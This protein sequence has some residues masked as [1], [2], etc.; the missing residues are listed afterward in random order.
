MILLEAT[1]KLTF[2]SL[3]WGVELLFHGNG[4]EEHTSRFEAGIG[5]YAPLRM[6]DYIIVDFRENPSGSISENITKHE[7]L[8]IR[9]EQGGKISVGNRVN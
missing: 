3:R 2:L 5:K 4:V 8:G 9:V 7:M 1:A 6:N